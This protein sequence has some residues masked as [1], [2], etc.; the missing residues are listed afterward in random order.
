MRDRQ[1]EIAVDRIGTKQIL[2]QTTSN[3]RASLGK[4]GHS[5]AKAGEQ[6]GKRADKVQRPG[7]QS[8]A[9]VRVPRMPDLPVPGGAQASDQPGL[10]AALLGARLGWRDSI[11]AAVTGLGYELVDIERAQRGLLRVTIDRIPGRAYALPADVAPD[12][13]PQADAEALPTSEFVTVEDC[14]IVTRQLQ[15][16]LEVEGLDYA[17]LEVSSPGLD[18]PLKT[19]ADFRRF[20][21][22]AVNVT[23][24]LPFQ[25][26][27]AWQGVL[28]AGPQGADWQLV[29]KEG[30]TE[31][32]LGFRFEE[33]RE[34]RLVPVVDF[35]GRRPAGT[36]RAGG[37]AGAAPQAAAAPGVEGG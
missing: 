18:R 16:L 32:V 28:G 34:A 13:M 19:E 27:K 26:R 21:G 1:T 36:A 17:R 4:P 6:A 20:A 23:L 9:G 33:V 12:G 22:L 11:V 7:R 2:G 35:K 29:F 30:K 15:Y 5:R 31:Q 8:V 3:S 10:V 25:G 37:Q 24:K 14:E